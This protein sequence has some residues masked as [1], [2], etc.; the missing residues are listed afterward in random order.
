[1]TV[2]AGLGNPPTA[3]GGNIGKTEISVNATVSGNGTLTTWGIY[4]GGQ[5]DRKL[6]IFRDD[7]TNYIFITETGLVNVPAGYTVGL[8]CN[9]AVINGDLIGVYSTNFQG[10][11]SGTSGKEVT[12]DMTSSTL[13]TNWSNT[14]V[15]ATAMEAQGLQDF[16]VSLSGNDGNDGILWGTSKQTLYAGT[17]LVS[18]NDVLHITFGNYSAQTSFQLNKTLNILC[19]AF[20]GG[21]TGTVTFPP[22]V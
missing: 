2:V 16:Y 21:G 17:G 19:E 3:F 7:G 12:G 13:K 11:W 14:P 5:A 20:S 8:S 6:K 18:N 4:A 15:G 22:T 1:M 9:I 10:Q